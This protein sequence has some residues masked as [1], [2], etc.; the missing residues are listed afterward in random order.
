M[1][2]V[3]NLFFLLLIPFQFFFFLNTDYLPIQYNSVYFDFATILICLSFLLDI[4]VIGKKINNNDSTEF[5]FIIS[6]LLIFYGIT[7]I[8]NNRFISFLLFLFLFLFFITYRNKFTLK[9]SNIFGKIRKFYIAFLNHQ[10][11][12]ENVKL[13]NLTLYFFVYLNLITS[14]LIFLIKTKS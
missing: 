7:I 3:F 12:I 8:A 5:S 2:T 9:L 4:V 1:Q 10:F 13:K 11:S 6:K 14:S